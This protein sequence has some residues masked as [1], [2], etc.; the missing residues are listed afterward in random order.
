MP[1]FA[2]VINVSTLN[3]SN[4]FRLDDPNSD[5]HFSLSSGGDVN[6]DGLNDL[7]IGA[8]YAGFSNF[9]PGVAWVV[10]G[11]TSSPAV[12]TLAAKVAAGTAYRFQTGTNYDQAGF[13]GNAGDV[14]GDGFDDF[15]IG[16]PKADPDAAYS[17]R[18][19]SYLVFGG[20]AKLEAFDAADGTN[21]NQVSLNSIAPATGYRFDGERNYDNAGYSVSGAG[22]F[23]GDGFEDLLIGAR[24]ADPNTSG[25][26]GGNE[27]AS[28]IVF[29]GSANL[30]DLDNDDGVTDGRIDLAQVGSG[31]GLRIDGVTFNSGDNSG[32]SVA[33]V[34]DVNGDGFDDVLIGAL[35]ADPNGTDNNEG[36][37][38]LVLGRPASFFAPS[39]LELASLGG[40]WGVFRF[41]GESANN[42]AAAK[43]S[44]L[45]DVNGDG[46][47]DFGIA[48]PNASPNGTWSGATY[49]VFG[50]N[51]FGDSNDLSA[52]DG[53]DGFRLEGIRGYDFAGAGVGS[54]GDVNGDGFDDILVSAYGMDRTGEGQ[55]GAVFVVFG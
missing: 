1:E 34:G 2:P 39:G 54:A 14:N 22:D 8:P 5:H 4:G 48:A 6:G 3:G 17:N 12:Q 52:L 7:L 42:F 29:G 41:D 27:G 47:A 32:R 44:A 13:V 15:I 28:Y 11:T 35:R 55:S 50:R 45:G 25:G 43:V 37:A 20:A 36:A 16:A 46:L 26:V 33:M 53:D 30:V 38:Y 9:D 10:F 24:Y 19:A 23:N 18:G 31:K 40:R 21:D 49:V 51:A